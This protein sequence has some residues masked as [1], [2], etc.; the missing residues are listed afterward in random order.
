MKRLP[1]YFDYVFRFA[2]RHYAGIRAGGF[3]WRSENG[4]AFESQLDELE[5]CIGSAERHL[6]FHDR[7]FYSEL[8]KN[9][10]T[11]PILDLSTF[12]CGGP[13]A[14]HTEAALGYAKSLLFIPRLWA[15][16]RAMTA[17]D[18]NQILVRSWKSAGLLKVEDALLC[19]T[20]AQ[21]ECANAGGV[22]V[23]G[24]T[25]PQGKVI[26]QRNDRLTFDMNSPNPELAR[27]VRKLK[28]Q[29]RSGVQE[30]T[31]TSKR[32]GTGDSSATDSPDWPDERAEWIRFSVTDRSIC[33]GD[34]ELVGLREVGCKALIEVWKLTK[35]VDV[36]TRSDVLRLAGRDPNSSTRPRDLFKLKGNNKIHPVFDTVFVKHQHGYK[37]AEPTPQAVE[38]YRRKMKKI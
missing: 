31:S 17:E 9:G 2:N 3:C 36:A 6:L 11:E 22:L 12:G 4:L 30:K 19:V 25:Q 18:R 5:R 7:E 1:T 10:P 13:H 32:P 27:K 33:W 37:I 16:E 29:A 21:R 38:A 8:L 35:A 15:K 20:L 23:H 24:P 26:R 28:D 34:V 14:T